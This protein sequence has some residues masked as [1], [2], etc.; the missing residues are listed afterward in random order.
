MQLERSGLSYS[1]LDDLHLDILYQLEHNEH[2]IKVEDQWRL[3]DPNKVSEV[4]LA[5][6]F[7]I[8]VL[9][10]AIFWGGNRASHGNNTHQNCSLH[11]SVPIPYVTWSL[12]IGMPGW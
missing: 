12:A 5:D 9:R 1:S 10:L 8:Q 4:S 11:V 7:S 3:K 6:D 2:L